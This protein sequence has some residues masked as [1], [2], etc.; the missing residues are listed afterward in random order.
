MVSIEKKQGKDTFSALY[1][2]KDE[3][4]TLSWQ[5]KPFK[6]APALRLCWPAPPQLLLFLSAQCA[7]LLG[8]MR[9]LATFHM[10]ECRW[11]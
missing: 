10:P 6:V 2:L 9:S 8:Q 11:W 1:G 7:V 5:R 3:A 4:A